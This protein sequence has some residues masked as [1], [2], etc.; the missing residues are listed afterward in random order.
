MAGRPQDFISLAPYLISDVG[1]AFI[2]VGLWTPLMGTV[3]ALNEIWMASLLYS[4]RREDA[5]MYIFLAVVAASVA[6]LGPGAWSVDARLFG[7]KRFDM[8]RTRKSSL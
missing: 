3:V 5:W 7:R 1:A 8:D 2:L 4:H 6:M